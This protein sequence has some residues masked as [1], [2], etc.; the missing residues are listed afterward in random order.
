ML[1]IADISFT[2]PFVLAPLAGYSDLPFRLLCREYGAGLTVSEMISCHGLIYGQ[3]KTE[4]M[5]ASN[6]DDKPVSFQLFGADPEIMGEAAALL[7]DFHPTFIDINMGCPVKKVTKRGAGSA[8]LKDIHLAEKILTAVCKKSQVPVTV[9]TRAGIDSENITALE[10]IRMCQN[11]GA[12]AITIHGRT[13]A[14]GFTGRA[15]WNIIHQA[16]KIAT[17]PIIG[18]GD[19]ESHA[20]GLSK[21]EEY[22]CDGIMIGRAALGNPWVFQKEG[23]PDDFQDIIPAVKRHLTLMEAHLD[24][25]KQLAYIKNHTGRYFINFPGSS[26]IRQSIHSMKSFGK[27]LSLINS[28]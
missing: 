22:G 20:S 10:F 12:A 16:K 26:H 3:E 4:K 18:N 21:M 23:R 28:L 7:N 27:L 15:D 19:V 17:V 14:Q 24:T 11:S 9:K 2:S 25:D 5:L 1:Q 8:L 13:W 6:A